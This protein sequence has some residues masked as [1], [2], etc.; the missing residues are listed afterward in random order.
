MKKKRIKYHVSAYNY[1]RIGD[2]LRACDYDNIIDAILYCIG[3]RYLYITL[4]DFIISKIDLEE[5]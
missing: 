3:C 1:L 5:G 4:D 2:V